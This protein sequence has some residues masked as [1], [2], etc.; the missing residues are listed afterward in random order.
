[1]GIL[2]VG[3]QMDSMQAKVCES[4]FNTAL[5]LAKSC[6]LIF[7]FFLQKHRTLFMGHCVLLY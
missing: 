2:V 1:M 5:A 3:L 4:C 6:A 7:F